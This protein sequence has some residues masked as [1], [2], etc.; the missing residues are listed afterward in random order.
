MI[1]Y[2]NPKPEKPAR[3][4]IAAGK[5]HIQ[6]VKNLPCA[7]C[8]K[9][10]PS[11]AHHVIHGRYSQRKA[12]D[13]ATIPLCKQ[14]HQW[15]NGAIHNGKESWRQAHGPDYSYLGWVQTMIEQLP[16]QGIDDLL[17]QYTFG[18]FGKLTAQIKEQATS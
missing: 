1:T 9:A 7:V 11:D 14:H 5:R 15:G 13:T 8:G 17:D 3:G 10:P 16:D 12:P 2:H 6:R 18:L 4:S